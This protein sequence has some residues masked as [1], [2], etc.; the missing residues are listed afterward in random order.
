[1]DIMHLR[2]TRGAWQRVSPLS[3]SWCGPHSREGW[4]PGWELRPS[5]TL[6]PLEDQDRLGSPASLGPRLPG[7][8]S[9]SALGGLSGLVDDLQVSS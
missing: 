3:C 7:P 5:Q 4:W 2:V 1:M 6:L 8:R 9:L